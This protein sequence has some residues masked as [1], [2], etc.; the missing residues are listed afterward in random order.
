[1][2][3]RI[4][5]KIRL[6]LN[7]LLIL[8]I[9]TLIFAFTW[10]PASA[11]SL[12]GSLISTIWARENQWQ[13]AEEEQRNLFFYEY[14][15]LR[16]SELWTEKLTMHL[17]GRIGW[18]RFSQTDGDARFDNLLYQ[19]YLNYRVPKNI[20]LRFGRQFLP[21][22]VG[23]WQM[24]GVRLSIER[25]RIAIPTLYG[26]V[27]VAPWTIT[28]DKK[29]VVGC[30]L[31]G[32]NASFI[33][34]QVSLLTLFSKD[35]INRAI[36][37]FRLNA[38][39]ASIFDVHRD[40]HKRFSFTGRTS[41]DLLTQQIIS[42]YGYVHF[43]PIPPIHTS[44]EYQ[45]ETPLYPSDSIFSIFAV[46]P[47]RQFSFGLDLNITEWLELNGGYARQSYDSGPIHRYSSG[48]SFNLPLVRGGQRKNRFVLSHPG[49][50]GNERIFEFRLERLSDIDAEY[51]RARSYIGKNLTHRLSVSLNHYYNNYRFSQTSQV[52]DAYSFQCAI[53]YQIHRNLQAFVRIEDNINPDYEYNVRVIGQLRMFFN[54]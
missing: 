14:V 19:G 35:D 13:P 12:S 38:P 29:G 54:L 7:S 34:S 5:T 40:T 28:G 44:I 47:L 16:A 25:F 18:S 11:L 48:V 3:S 50:W 9:A 37:G 1:M 26:G 24:D 42:G 15:H 36:L 8:I 32:L 20:S 6:F 17:R 53:R 22:D 39:R 4:S 52:S 33:Q 30:E 51:W 41:V 46:E 45:H 31:R 49:K 21:N 27:A 2:Y 23:F 43:C 10:Q